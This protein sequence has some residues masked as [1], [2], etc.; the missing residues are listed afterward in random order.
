MKIN[1]NTE[2]YYNQYFDVKDLPETSDY[3]PGTTCNITCIAMITG[4]D[5]ND[6]LNW[7]IIKYQ[8][9][10]QKHKWQEL[11]IDYLEISGFQCEP[12]L[13]KAAYPKAR[14]IT[15]NEL[16]KC[17]NEISQGNIIF[18]HKDGHYELMTGFEIDNQGNMINFIFNDPAGN[19]KIRVA[20]RSRD[21]G[22]GVYYSKEMIQREKIYGMCYSI[23][24]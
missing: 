6:V 11:L 14:S 4:E 17:M 22:H 7:F 24:I 15:D 20:D 3:E 16:K 5:P 13:D 19:R 1:N 21:S 23:N 12:I 8:G 9:D 2:A 10:Q 18:F